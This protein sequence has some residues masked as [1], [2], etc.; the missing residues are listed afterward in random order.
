MESSKN[1]HPEVHD[2]G[3]AA[4]EPLAVRA[5]VAHGD[6]CL[7]IQCAVC[8]DSW[9]DPIELSCEHIFCR[10]C[11]RGPVCPLCQA[12]STAPPRR[13]HRSLV[14]IAEQTPV[15]CTKCNWTG[16]RRDQHD[17]LECCRQ[18][19]AAADAKSRCDTLNEQPPVAVAYSGAP[20]VATA[21]PAE[22][23][24]SEKMAKKVARWEAKALNKMKK[25]DRAIARKAAQGESV[26]N[27]IQAKIESLVQS[28]RM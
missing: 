28:V 1:L 22:P 13:P 3:H 23:M 17:S 19:D 26:V 20:L 27:R 21:P 16:L 8:L 12:V 6:F 25:I 10:T 2:V 4:D 24:L 7:E 18:S 9:V 15:R 11:C 5:V 14:A